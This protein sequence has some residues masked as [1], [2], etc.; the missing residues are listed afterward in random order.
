MWVHK[1]AEDIADQRR[2]VRTRFGEPI[3][4]GLLVF[5]CLIVRRWAGI[6][7]DGP[8]L[9]RPA[10]VTEFVVGTAILGLVIAVI[11]YLLQ[12]IFGRSVFELL[13]VQPKVLICDKCYQ[14]KSSVGRQSCDCGGTFE[15]FELWKWVDEPSR[16]EGAEE[17]RPF[18]AFVVGS[19]SEPD[20]RDNE[21][22]RTGR[23]GLG[24]TSW[25]GRTAGL[26]TGNPRVRGIWNPA[27][28]TRRG[29]C[30][31][32]LDAT[33]DPAGTGT[34]A[35]AATVI[36]IVIAALVNVPLP[37]IG[38]MAGFGVVVRYV[39]ILVRRRRQITLRLENAGDVIVDQERSRAA[40]FLPFDHKPRWVVLEL[41]EAFADASAA[42][43]DALGV[44]C[45]AG[46]I[47]GGNVLCVILL[48]V[49]GFVLAF[50][51][52]MISAGW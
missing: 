44:K 50:G 9:F 39:A 41:K 27:V 2:N 11:S 22:R 33:Y 8:N 43:R 47:R 36:A 24:V 40:F 16:Q 20:L 3:F 4:L 15:D 25:R 26:C 42:I 37:F 30:T 23:I 32:T 14:T 38:F 51:Y 13:T 17:N 18:T 46:T 5:A 35:L 52:C 6:P 1:T 7:R 21:L 31:L 19:H 48:L 29:E 34:L 28:L 49:V 10:T 12:V 45:R